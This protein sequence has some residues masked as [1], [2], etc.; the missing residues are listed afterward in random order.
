[1][2]AGFAARDQAAAELAFDQFSQTGRQVDQQPMKKLHPRQIGRYLAV[3]E[4]DVVGSARHVKVMA[5]QHQRT[6]VGRQIGPGQV[7][8]DVLTDA[9]AATLHRSTGGVAFRN[10]FAVDEAV[11]PQFH[12]DGPDSDAPDNRLRGCLGTAQHLQH[13]P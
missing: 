7:R 2:T 10:R 11:A 13:R 6:G 3:A 1:M 12:A 9:D 5:D 8:A 4:V